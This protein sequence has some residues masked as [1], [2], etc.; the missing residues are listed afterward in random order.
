[1]TANVGRRLRERFGPL[2]VVLLALLTAVGLWQTHRGRP[3]QER[4]V[5]LTVEPE[6]VMGTSCRLAVTIGRSGARSAAKGL[7]QAEEVIRGIESRMSVW[8]EDS[9]ISRLN[10]APAGRSVPLSSETRELLARARRAADETRGAFDVTVGPLVLLWRRAAEAGR[11]P[12]PAEL[13]EARSR[14]RWEHF[15]P[16]AGGLRKSSEG[17]RVDLGGIAKGYAIDRAVAI[18]SARAPQGGMVDIGGDVRVWGRPPQSDRWEVDVQDP[19]GSRP[20]VSLRVAEGAVCTSGDY[21]RFVEVE[22]RRYSHIIDP[23][24]ARPAE[25]VVSVTVT[26]PDAETADIWATALSVLGP[27]GVLVMP[28]ENEVLFLLGEPQRRRLIAT[29]GMA[30]LLKEIPAD[31]EIVRGS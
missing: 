14:S 24:S 23:R 5:A 30:A 15:E 7:E 2:L 6:G 19:F 22:G 11:V 16:T 13:A 29:P 8:L 28:I 3:Q 9:E 17:A 26:A 21:A 1:V 25:G 10:R 12:S 31:L 18:L 20:L 27:D 4:L